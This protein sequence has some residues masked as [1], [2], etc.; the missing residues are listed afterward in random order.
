MS[1]HRITWSHPRSRSGS[2]SRLRGSLAERLRASAHDRAATAEELV[3]EA[4]REMRS[5][6][7]ERPEEEGALQQGRE[8]EAGWA[9]WVRGQ[10]W[11]GP[12]AIFVDA[13]RR[14]FHEAAERASRDDV[15]DRSLKELEAWLSPHDTGQ[16]GNPDRWSGVPLAP[17]QR[18]ARRG[19]VIPHALGTLTRGERILVHGYSPT[20]LGALAAARKSGLFPRVLLGEGGPDQSGKRMARELTRMGIGVRLTWD[21]AV[22]GAVDEVDRI[23]LGTEAIGA[24]VFLGLVGTGLLLREAI[25]TEVPTAVLC[26]GDELM[27]GG[28]ALPPIWGEEE[29]WNLWSHDPDGVELSSQPYE[30]VNADLVGTWVTEAGRETLGELC[31]RA[32]R[33]VPAPPCVMIKNEQGLTP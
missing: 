17:G 6:L 21:A 22:L 4:A 31:L 33:P 23:W 28:E 1:A 7:S 12:C 24:G 9:E 15:R 32:M 18:L 20:V 5:W 16:P 30:Q 3:V 19:D 27:P 11:R 13:I 26:T 8:L 29:T 2:S 10:G 14:V 25:R